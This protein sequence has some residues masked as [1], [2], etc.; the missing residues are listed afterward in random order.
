[1]SS[2][3]CGSKLS[4]LSFVINKTQLMMEWL[5]T[6]VT[7]IHRYLNSAEF[8]PPG[9]LHLDIKEVGS[10]NP[11][12]IMGTPKFHGTSCDNADICMQEC[13]QEKIPLNSNLHMVNIS[14]FVDS[15]FEFSLNVS[16]SM[17]LSSPLPYYIITLS[18]IYFHNNDLIQSAVIY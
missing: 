1:M 14:W 3:L 8:S 12:Q 5:T 13:P 15:A 2:L 7:F 9:C 16:M 10:W 18:V 6:P 11:H 4:C 17:R